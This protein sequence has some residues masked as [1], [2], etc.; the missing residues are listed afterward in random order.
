MK[1]FKGAAS[2]ARRLQ[3]DALGTVNLLQCLPGGEQAL[4][5]FQEVS[6]AAEVA[7]KVSSPSGM[8]P[9]PKQAHALCLA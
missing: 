8:V 9:L 5:A 3:Q 1:C 4:T 6:A 2:P 7:Q